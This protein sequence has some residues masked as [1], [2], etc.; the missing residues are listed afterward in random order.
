MLGLW[1]LKTHEA[2]IIRR[3]ILRFALQCPAEKCPKAAEFVAA[4]RKRDAEWVKDVE[5]L[6]QLEIMPPKKPD[7]APA[8]P[9][10]GPPGK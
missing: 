3:A 2:P 1:D 7:A 4:Q 10:V 8:S 6:L 5:E 9:R